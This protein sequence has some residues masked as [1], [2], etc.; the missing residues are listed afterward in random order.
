MAPSLFSVASSCLS[1]QEFCR[2]VNLR[3]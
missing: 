3:L 2:V 1:T